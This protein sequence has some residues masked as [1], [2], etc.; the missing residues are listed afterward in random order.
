[1]SPLLTTATGAARAAG[2]YIMRHYQQ[3]DQLKV[4]AKQARDYVSEVDRNAE[5]IIIDR[6]SRA[7]PDHAI[8]AE[9]SGVHGEATDNIQWIIDPLDGTTNFLHRFPQFAVSIA[10]RD[11]GELEI[12]VVYDPFKQE[13]FT[14]KRGSGSQLDGRRIRVSRSGPLE[15]S[16]IGTGFPFR[17]DQNIEDYLP[18]LQKTMQSTAG[19]RRAGAAALD[20]AYVA[21]GRLDGFFELG[22]KP[23]DVAAG[24]LLIREAGGVVTDIKDDRSDPVDSG[25]VLAGNPRIHEELGRLLKPLL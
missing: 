18:L 15:H 4:T 5:A 17:E 20:L 10:A 11:R 23:W 12:A 2:D 3:A 25:R 9:E 6:I 22:L 7:Y 16:L 24:A 1:M 21:A 8:L 14:A 13:L 19:V